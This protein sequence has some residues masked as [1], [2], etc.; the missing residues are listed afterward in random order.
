MFP[1]V[2][3]HLPDIENQAVLTEYGE[4][5]EEASKHPDI[6]GLEIGSRGGGVPGATEHGDEGEESGDT[7]SHPAGDMFSRDEEGEPGDEDEHGGRDHGL[8]YMER[9]PSVKEKTNF[10]S[11]F[12][13][14]SQMCVGLV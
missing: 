1:R 2:L 9:E 3:S 5:C 7:E 11:R 4:D 10:K 13:R 14:F 6:S 12:W 8:S